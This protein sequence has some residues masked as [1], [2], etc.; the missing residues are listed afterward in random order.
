MKALPG[1]YLSQPRAD[2]SSA[3]DRFIRLALV[4][5]LATTEEALHRIAGTV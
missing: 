3:G 4:H 5:D 1:G 2:G